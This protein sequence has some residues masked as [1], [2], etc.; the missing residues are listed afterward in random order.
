MA[1]TLSNV[2]PQLLAMG[3][4]ALRERAVM[5][6][7]VNR[8]YDGMAAEKGS[9]IDIPLSFDATVRNVTPAV[10]QAANERTQFEG[11]LTCFLPQ[12]EIRRAL[13]IH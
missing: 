4:D 3:L 2:I 6:R 13:S 11:R 8:S 7:L 9:T 1:N 10:T 5:P 12:S